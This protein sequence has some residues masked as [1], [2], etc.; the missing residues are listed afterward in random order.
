MKPARTKMGHFSIIVN[1]LK[2][3]TIVAESSVLNVVG[4]LDPPLHR[5]KFAAKVVGWFKS[6]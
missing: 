4:F 2:L 1:D 5:N 6:K 3:F